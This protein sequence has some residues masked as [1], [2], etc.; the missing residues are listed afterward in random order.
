M[1]ITK[2]N[3]SVHKATLKDTGLHEK[4]EEQRKQ[5]KA[6]C[7]PLTHC[8]ICEGRIVKHRRGVHACECRTVFRRYFVELYE[9]YV[10]ETPCGEF[11]LVA[12]VCVQDKYWRTIGAFNRLEEMKSENVPCWTCYRR[13][14]ADISIYGLPYRPDLTH[15]GDVE[16]NP[17]PLIRDLD[18]FN[19][20]WEIQGLEEQGL[21]SKFVCGALIHAL[22]LHWLSIVFCARCAWYDFAHVEE[23][24]AGF[25]FGC[26]GMNSLLTRDGWKGP[27][28]ALAQRFDAWEQQVDMWGWLP[29]EMVEDVYQYLPED[30]WRLDDCL[31]VLDLALK[32]YIRALDRDMADGFW[33]RGNFDLQ[34]FFEGVEDE[35]DVM[36]DSWIRDLLREGVEP[37]PGPRKFVRRVKNDRA[38]VFP[39]VVQSR[40]LQP[41]QLDEGRIVHEVERW[42]KD[43]APHVLDDPKLTGYLI[44]CVLNE[45]QIYRCR[46][47]LSIFAALAPH[48]SKV[49]GCF[50]EMD[51]DL[52]VIM[53]IRDELDALKKAVIVPD[54]L[55]EACSKEASK[56]QCRLVMG[57]LMETRSFDPAVAE[58][59]EDFSLFS[60]A[61]FSMSPKRH[62]DLPSSYCHAQM[63]TPSRKAEPDL[64]LKASLEAL[65][66]EAREEMLALLD[67]PTVMLPAIG[68]FPE[69]I[70]PFP[71][72][73]GDVAAINQAVLE[74][75]ESLSDFARGRWSQKLLRSQSIQ[76]KERAATEKL[77][78]V[79]QEMSATVREHGEKFFRS[80]STQ[81]KEQAATE[82]VHPAKREVFAIAQEY[83]R[84]FA[85]MSG[86]AKAKVKQLMVEVGADIWRMPTLL[87]SVKLAEMD[88]ER[89]K[90]WLTYFNAFPREWRFLLEMRSKLFLSAD[91]LGACDL[92]PCLN[93]LAKAW[94]ECPEF[95]P[96]GKALCVIG[97]EGLQREV[98]TKQPIFRPH[99][100]NIHVQE[101]NHVARGRDVRF[102]V[103]PAP[104]SNGLAFF[105]NEMWGAQHFE[106]LEKSGWVPRE[107]FGEFCLYER[108][109]TD[110]LAL[111]GGRRQDKQ[112]WWTVPD[113]FRL[114]LARKTLALALWWSYN[115]AEAVGVFV[116]SWA[117]NVFTSGASLH[118]GSYVNACRSLVEQ[119]FSYAKHWDLVVHGTA[120]FMGQG[121]S[122][123]NIDLLQVRA[124]DVEYLSA[125]R[126][127]LAQSR[128]V[129]RVY[130]TLLF[131]KTTRGQV[132]HPLNPAH[133]VEVASN[134][135][136]SIPL[137]MQDEARKDILLDVEL[138][139]ES[140]AECFEQVEESVG[141]QEVVREGHMQ[142]RALDAFLAG[143]ILC[144]YSQ[145]HASALQSI[146]N[147][148][149]LAREG[150]I[151][152][153]SPE[154]EWKKSSISLFD[155]S[156]WG[157]IG[158]GFQA[159]VRL[160]G[161]GSEFHS[162]VIAQMA[163]KAVQ[164]GRFVSIYDLPDYDAERI[165]VELVADMREHVYSGARPEVLY[166]CHFNDLYVPSPHAS[167]WTVV[168]RCGKSLVETE[169]E[170]DMEFHDYC[171]SIFEK[172]NIRYD[173]VSAGLD[174]V[175]LD[176]FLDT[177]ADMNPASRRRR[178]DWFLSYMAGNKKV[179]NASMKFFTKTDEVL[180]MADPE[181]EYGD[182]F[183]PLGKPRSIFNAS[184]LC[185]STTQPELSVLKKVVKEKEDGSQVQMGDY[186]VEM[187]RVLE[188]R[189]TV[190]GEEWV[191]KL[192]YMAD[193]DNVQDAAW[194]H[195]AW[196][197]GDHTIH[198]CVGGDDNGTVMMWNG[199]RIEIEGDLSMCDQSMR[200]LFRRIYCEFLLKAGMPPKV[201]DAIQRT[202]SEG[203][204]Y[205]DRSGQLMC[206]IHFLQEQLKTGVAHTSFSN[207]F[208]VG[209]LMFHGLQ[210]LIES[211][212]PGE[213]NECMNDLAVEMKSFLEQHWLSLGITMKLQIY[214]NSKQPLMT[215]HKRYFVPW[216]NGAG[217]MA[218]AL[219]STIVKMC[220]VRAPTVMNPK[221]FK[222]RLVE[223]ARSRASIAC[224]PLL[225]AFMMAVGVDVRLP[226][227]TTRIA[228]SVGWLFN[229]NVFNNGRDGGYAAGINNTSWAEL[230]G[231]GEFDD[232]MWFMWQRYGVTKEEF[233]GMIDVA[234]RL[235][236]EHCYRFANTLQGDFMWTLFKKDYG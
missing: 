211:F 48:E 228:S 50:E 144:G 45:S 183:T 67:E 223:S 10:W 166:W 61:T 99:F 161:T 96:Q 115:D 179:T 205:F 28:F 102:L 122:D 38:I 134:A 6:D 229:S 131:T 78:P 221:T 86:V 108:I 43:V 178:L 11:R 59:R 172:W 236:V 128:I 66:D 154:E 85:V 127:W 23:T 69:Q 170:L 148:L 104:H 5:G 158:S 189:F 168:M 4:S 180:I 100:L 235:D 204:S 18:L 162:P 232:H 20:W 114:M 145:A 175:T 176:T 177:I 84:K 184:D 195:E 70:F 135:A 34:L 156:L 234:R 138:A 37:N 79:T 54:P 171:S 123:A 106:Y 197:A 58:P 24:E 110:Y 111:P 118:D 191:I 203:A 215:F 64:L 3:Y 167:I 214:I 159:D 97:W 52:V 92:M 107:V 222:K 8:N 30:R 35:I 36:E 75:R 198:I 2:L 196:S 137:K 112:L 17:G 109:P 155:N 208:I 181:C 62:V 19:L 9:H 143:T 76:G 113:R 224:N 212:E 63:E 151:N 13:V 68:P 150:I 188:H 157:E 53:V 81:G 49:C 153:G 133:E 173:P 160:S 226:S 60:G 42:L 126:G 182:A 140:V 32:P 217:F 202:Y 25:C 26:D 187:P 51:F 88:E 80:Q 71:K 101:G 7:S 83:Q 209:L 201:V 65:V 87:R 230:E 98:D 220:A 15:D 41:R 31:I 165:S 72:T 129:D 136:E 194:M 119:K 174:S 82:K 14:K 77:E 233:E 55:E 46:S 130:H 132:M 190:R 152:R 22:E 231:D 120:T 193:S 139:G 163:T 227:V 74:R 125:M 216:Q 141:L 185:F 29:R 213:K 33:E 56:E 1:S 105:Y 225:R 73:H 16:S 121:V 117:N 21:D 91:G 199:M 40:V 27:T 200:E 124:T 57:M 147:Q 47:C 219:P 164:N 186:C 95:Y 12:G 169:K 89:K 39:S 206:E 44:N 103:G 94:Q 149:H 210:R 90:V 218:C 146:Q 207:T 116:D 192:R 142:A 93:V